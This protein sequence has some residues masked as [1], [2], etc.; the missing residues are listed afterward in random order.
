MTFKQLIHRVSN[1]ILA[2]LGLRLSYRIGNE[3]HSDMARL[4]GPDDVHTIIDGGAHHGAFS[5]QLAAHY[6]N[7]TI[8]AFEP[9]PA[10]YQALLENV[11]RL[12]NVRA[13]R[14]ALGAATSQAMFYA[15]AS[16]LTNSLRPN[17]DANDR[18]FGALVTPVD[19]YRVDVVSL[20]AFCSTE[21]CQRIDIMKLDLQ[22]HELEALKGL[23]ALL[24]GVQI[25]LLEV[26][27][28]PLYEHAP[29]FSEV[30]QYLRRRGMAFYQFYEL[31]RAPSDGRLLYGD[32]MFVRAERL[33]APGV[34]A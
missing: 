30:E 3:P 33:A 14:L 4:L 26:Q 2:P 28:V 12:P 24:E 11:A 25:L 20:E 13:H 6:P 1:K 8:H 32:A 34:P 9:T 7:A 27:F 31:V 23:G 29:M 5:R 22:G 10:T 18:Y 21:S 15:N 17:A 16:P 19:S